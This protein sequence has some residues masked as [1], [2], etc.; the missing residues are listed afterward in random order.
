MKW[1]LIAF[2]VLGVAA[3]YSAHFTEQLSPPPPGATLLVDRKQKCIV[4]GSGQIRIL[5][6]A[7]GHSQFK[8]ANSSHCYGR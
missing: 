7:M 5:S 6:M 2:L 4:A 1:P 3:P 8:L